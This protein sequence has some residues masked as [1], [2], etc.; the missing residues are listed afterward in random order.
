MDDRRRDAAAGDNVM[1]APAALGPAGSGGAQ[2]AVGGPPHVRTPI[3]A[4][5][6]AGR[7]M[8]VTVTRDLHARPELD[9]DLAG[10]YMRDAI[11]HGGYRAALEYY[12]SE[13]AKKSETAWHRLR[14]R[15]WLLGRLGLYGQLGTWLEEASEW[16]DF[17][18][19]SAAAFPPLHA[20]YRAPSLWMEAPRPVPRS[21]DHTM[22][23]EPVATTCPDAGTV[24]GGIWAV[25]L[26]L[27]AAGPICSH[28]GLGAAA[29][30][31]AQ[32]AARRMPG[33][34]RGGRRY[35]PLRGAR[36]H[37]AP[38]VCHRWIIADIDFDPRPVN[39]PHYYYDLT[40]EGREALAAAKAAGAPWPRATE[41][42]ASGLGG[43]TLPDLLENACRFCGPAPGLGKMKNGLDRLAGAW[44]AQESGRL[45]PPVEAEDRALVDLG[46]TARW[47]DTGDSLGS[48]FDH[49]LYLM[50][51]IESVRTVAGE[52]E[53]STGAESAVLRALI[54]TIHGL[55]RR[56]GREVAAATLP[57]A[58]TLHSVRG[59][60]ADMEE[61][62]QLRAP[63]TSPTPALISDSYYCLAEYCKSRRLATDPCSLPLSK[64]LTADERAT[65]IKVLEK[66]LLSHSGED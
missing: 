41:S 18:H 48:S 31:V 8:T 26:I 40:D 17:D 56:H 62:A 10:T 38:E 35:D 15:G 55:C 9:N 39:E 19:I 21:A 30:L 36:L 49:L 5:G 22:T 54:G 33:S 53:P 24:P 63:Y 66:D 3:G 25:M 65:V 12:G 28:A 27:D 42:A 64:A 50:E 58:R 13:E 7:S 59:G 46:S 43:L 61:G 34:E 6:G 23:L 57:E 16:P 2:R 32:G 37:G 60:H 29:H 47:P 14:A 51:V 4:R 52:A 11:E 1:A 45:A 44:D 20:D